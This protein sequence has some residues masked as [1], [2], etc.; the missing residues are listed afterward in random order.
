MCREQV[1]EQ[2]AGVE[3]GVDHVRPQRQLA[4]ADAVEQVFQD[5]GDFGEIGKA[6][7]AGRALD[8]MGGAEDGVQLLF[9]RARPGRGR[10]AGL[11]ASR[12]SWA[13]SKKTW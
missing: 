5:V 4:L 9:V 3:E 1:L 11:H 2:V 6:E 10:A 7:G 12:C 13:S 8:R